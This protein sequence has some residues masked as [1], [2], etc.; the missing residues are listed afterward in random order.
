M[1]KYIK[2]VRKLTDESNDLDNNTFNK[3][4][5]STSINNDLEE[6]KYHNENIIFPTSLEKD[7]LSST[8]LP[9]AD[10]QFSEEVSAK[11]PLPSSIEEG[12][13]YAPQGIN[14]VFPSKDEVKIG[15]DIS[16]LEQESK[17][18]TKSSKRQRKSYSDNRELLKEVRKTTSARERAF[19]RELKKLNKEKLK[20]E[21]KRLKLEIKN[22]KKAEKLAIKAA[23]IKENEAVKNLKNAAGTLT[24]DTLMALVEQRKNERVM[25][26]KIA[27]ER[28]RK[29]KEELEKLKKENAFLPKNSNIDFEELESII[30]NDK[31]DSTSEYDNS[32]PFPSSETPELTEQIERQLNAD[33]DINNLADN[34]QLKEEVRKARRE[35]RLA[36]RELERARRENEAQARKAERVARESERATQKAA[37]ELAKEV[38]KERLEREKLTAAALAVEERNKIQSIQENRIGASQEIDPSNGKVT[39]KL[40]RATKREL[41]RARK[42]AE[43]E[44]KEKLKELSKKSNLINKEDDIQEIESATPVEVGSDEN[45]SLTKV[46][47]N[48][49]GRGL[50]RREKAI[51]LPKD[52]EES[53]YIYPSAGDRTEGKNSYAQEVTG[54]ILDESILNSEIL[55]YENSYKSENSSSLEAN[56]I[57]P[58]KVDSQTTGERVSEESFTEHTL[59]SGSGTI[60]NEKTEKDIN[61][62]TNE[63]EKILREGKP[64]RRS[65]FRRA[66]PREDSNAAV[67]IEKNDILDEGRVSETLT[68]STFLPVEKVDIVELTAREERVRI[69]EEKIALREARYEAKVKAREEKN[70]AVK[71]EKLKR[72]LEREASRQARLNKD[73]TSSKDSENLITEDS[74]ISGSDER[75]DIPKWN[76]EDLV[77]ARESGSTNSLKIDR[78]NSNISP[79]SSN[80]T[81]LDVPP[82]A[83]N[84]DADL[85]LNGKSTKDV[86][87]EDKEVHSNPIPLKESIPSTSI[88]DNTN[89]PDQEVGVNQESEELHAEVEITELTTPVVTFAERDYIKQ[90]TI[91]NHPIEELFP[92]L[93]EEE[94]DNPELVKKREKD[95]AKALKERAKLEKIQNK[96]EAKREK[97]SEKN[98]KR[99]AKIL[100]KNNSILEKEAK[101]NALSDQKL[102][103][104]FQKF[105]SAEEKEKAKEERKIQKL[106]KTLIKDEALRVKRENKLKLAQQK[107]QEKESKAA[108]KVT[109]KSEKEA[110]RAN[111]KELKANEKQVKNEVK[112]IA[113]NEKK[114]NKLDAKSA[115]L[116][117]KQEKKQAARDAKESKN[118]EKNNL[119]ASQNQIGLESKDVKKQ[120]KAIQKNEKRE[121]KNYKREQREFAARQKKELKA[122]QEAEKI[123]RSQKALNL[124]AQAAA[125]SRNRSAEREADK[126]RK[127][128]E[129]INIE[130]P[131]VRENNLNV[132]STNRY[133]WDVES[134]NSLKAEV[135]YLDYDLPEPLPRR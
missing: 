133:S 93:T 100:A 11:L 114:K 59:G 60:D 84:H 72:A 27:G 53:P 127:R 77:S 135:N 86:Q 90:G 70:L 5:E 42:E 89:N 21:K 108:A 26:E 104:I 39:K 57:S 129:S 98:K 107:K 123:A 87:V 95:I 33:Q 105:S 48:K 80:E 49:R 7:N 111:E 132:S 131:V 99:E 29:N 110:S 125:N 17:I 120:R 124:S 94:K 18:A 20:E 96:T 119:K 62:T 109:A 82:Q 122:A 51:Q 14:E 74:I 1:D 35:K 50:F 75:N 92:E 103:L 73:S 10:K 34:D 28:N 102:P 113:K 15:E 126:I 37:E 2:G 66:V 52:F 78:E 16:A 55:E 32:A 83:I 68:E 23:R 121:L 58:Q 4:Q 36:E 6:T 128:A 22:K 88:K 45:S 44:I 38:E 24:Q 41:A 79:T 67:T 13:E 64:N 117:V 54:E 115:K 61:Y 56:Q 134:G 3:G 69:R 97:A 130:I 91:T 65:L 116:L 106:E 9:N 40:D 46:E 43:R 12:E 30:D 112:I 81:L 31:L 25:L 63:N 85:I 76:T 19:A 71:A 8:D 101:K 118:L 47:G